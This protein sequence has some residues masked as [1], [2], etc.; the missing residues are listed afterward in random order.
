MDIR[1]RAKKDGSTDS[2]LIERNVQLARERAGVTFDQQQA[3]EKRRK[4]QQQSEQQ[5]KRSVSSA[6]SIS[7]KLESLRQ[8]SELSADST[9]EM[10]RA[11][12]VLQ[13]QLSLGKGATQ[14][15]IALAGKYRAEIWD[16]FAAIRAQAADMKLIPEQAENRRHKQ[17]VADLKTALEQKTITQQQHDAAVEQMEQQHQVNLARI[18]ATQNAGVT[19]ASGSTRRYR[20]CSGVG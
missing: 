11:Q 2:D 8:Q 3:E 9:T 1:N 18:R 5:D 14:E 12:A 4:A 17:D 6:E 20:S 16:T 15:L 7:Q 19:P 10:S 13:A